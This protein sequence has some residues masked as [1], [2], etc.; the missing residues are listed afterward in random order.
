MQIHHVNDNR[1]QVSLNTEEAI[2]LIADLARAVNHANKFQLS[3][4]GQAGIVDDKY[5]GSLGF[6]IERKVNAA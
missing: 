1:I 2:G 4:L 6:V 5:P 3:N